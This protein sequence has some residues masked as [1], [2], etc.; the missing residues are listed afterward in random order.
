MARA[1][2][3]QG[4]LF[5]V[6]AERKI[7]RRNFFLREHPRGQGRPAALSD[8]GFGVIVGLIFMQDGIAVGVELRRRARWVC[9][10]TRHKRSCRSGLAWTPRGPFAD[11]NGWR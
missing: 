6:G 9:R 4:E 3:A 11:G 2:L 5:R 7:L 10:S 1:V 8:F